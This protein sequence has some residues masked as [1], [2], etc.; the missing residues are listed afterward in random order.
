MIDLQSAEQAC[1]PSDRPR[2][3]LRVFYR[4]QLLLRQSILATQWRWFF[5]QHDFRTLRLL[6]SI[7]LNLLP[8]LGWDEHW[9]AA[10]REYHEERQRKQRAG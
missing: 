3:S 8:P 7:N 1:K 2:P 10:A 5:P 6:P 9:S 4:K